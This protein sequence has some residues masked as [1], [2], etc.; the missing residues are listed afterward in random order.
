M[1][2]GKREQIVIGS[3]AAILL[4]VVL[5][6]L[7]FAPSADRF[8]A[9]KEARDSM[10][11]QISGL[12]TIPQN[13]PILKEFE[14]KTNTYL[15]K[16]EEGMKRLKMDE[17][18]CFVVPKIDEVKEKPGE[19][20]LPAYVAPTPAVV[21]G[22]TPT[23]NPDDPRHKRHLEVLSEKLP[24]QL[25]LI[26]AEV[27]KL[28]DASRNRGTQLSFLG[29]NPRFGWNVPTQLPANMQTSLLWDQVKSIA[30]LKA[31]M[32]KMNKTSTQYP[33]M[34]NGYMR[35]LRQLGLDLY[36]SENLARFG[37]FVPYIQRLFLADLILQK[38]ASSPNPVVIL[39]ETLT[40]EALLHY[41][42]I[43]LPLEPLDGLNEGKV[44]FLY[45]E[46]RGLNY[47]VEMAQK[48]GIKDVTAVTLRGFGY[49]REVAKM[50]DPGSAIFDPEKLVDDE[51]DDKA[52]LMQASLSG[53]GLTDPSAAPG[54][55]PFNSMGTASSTMDPFG[56]PLS[57]LLVNLMATARQT[58]DLG[59]A[60]PIRVSFVASNANGMAYLY[61]VLRENPMAELHRLILRSTGALNR[62]LTVQ[63]NAASSDVEMTATIL[64][65][66]KLFDTID[67]VR[68]MVDEMRGVTPTPTPT[69]TPAQ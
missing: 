61:E 11:Q 25:D 45:E 40:R 31:S 5:H 50:E 8:K 56:N 14:A 42:S 35:N 43:D 3:I 21:G 32:D 53:S 39:N 59:Y 17:P 67:T 65:V 58:G 34:L 44:Y 69:P 37:D 4:I 33:M 62:E 15:G 1:N 63:P 57:G 36:F 60:V 41:L 16:L 47:L 9:A 7:I 12:S 26:M 68:K 66:P 24:A 51:L 23:P 22:P 13:S 27:A 10:A 48:M 6:M 20:P 55:D 52:S 64:F 54:A 38:L 30:V 18:E 28:R 46:L 19:T 49:V 2:I 29:A